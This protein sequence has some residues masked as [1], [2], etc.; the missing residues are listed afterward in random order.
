MQSFKGKNKFSL[1]LSGYW[2][3]LQDCQRG[4]ENGVILVAC[5]HLGGS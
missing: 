3:R 2:G 5:V 4:E 1:V